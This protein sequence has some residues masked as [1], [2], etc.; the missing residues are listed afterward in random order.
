MNV[1]DGKVKLKSNY[2]RHQFFFLK[3]KKNKKK[4]M[5]NQFLWN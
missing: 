3:N 5:N 4:T 1:W 2:W